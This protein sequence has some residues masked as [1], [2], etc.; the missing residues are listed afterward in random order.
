[1]EGVAKAP[2]KALQ[3]YTRAAEDGNAQACRRLTRLYFLYDTSPQKYLKA[4]YWF[5][6]SELALLR[7]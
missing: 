1:M 7:L 6:R 5:M 2:E 3:W 4:A